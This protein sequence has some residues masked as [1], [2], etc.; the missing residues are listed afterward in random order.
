VLVFGNFIK[1]SQPCTASPVTFTITVNP[2]S[3]A[4]ITNG[5]VSGDISA[6]I[7]AASASPFIQQFKISGTGLTD[8]IT[9]T[10]PAGFELS[11]VPASGYAN[12]VSV[13]QSGGK[14]NEVK[15]YVRSAATANTG[16]ISGSVALTA[17]GVAVKYVGVNGWVNKLPAVNNP[18]DKIVAKGETLPAINLAGTANIYRWTND[19]PSIGLAASG[20]GDIT[21]F[22]AINTGSTPVVANIRVTPVPAQLAYISNYNDNTV[23]V[24]DIAGSR[25]LKPSLLVKAQQG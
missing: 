18:G 17:A 11:L 4:T 14:V 5:P 9:A 13:P 25:V 15:V 22:T 16:Y 20:E 10:A 7:G 3:T 6:C 8:N 24:V 21:S 2:T 23:S 12:S 19:N 1:K